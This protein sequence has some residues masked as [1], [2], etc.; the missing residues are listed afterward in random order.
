MKGPRLI[1]ITGPTN[2][3]KTTTA[4]LLSTCGFRVVSFDLLYRTLRRT[5]PRKDIHFR[6]VS[7]EVVR[8][9]LEMWMKNDSVILEGAPLMLCGIFE[10]ALAALDAAGVPPVLVTLAPSISVLRGRM[11]RRV[12]RRGIR[13]WME[14]RML[15]IG[16]Y[17]CFRSRERRMSMQ[18]SASRGRMLSLDRDDEPGE[19]TQRVCEFVG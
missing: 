14:R 18:V 6:H 11:E 10:D 15:L 9:A 16:S 13:A 4:S 5:M 8:R 17:A 1:F 2:A 19:V 3:G 7:R 12:I